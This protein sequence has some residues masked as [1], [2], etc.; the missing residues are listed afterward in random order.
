[1]VSDKLLGLGL[2]LPS[3]SPPVASYI[4][5]KRAGNLVFVSGQLPMHNGT[6]TMTGPMNSSRSIEEAQQ[7][8]E[9]CFLNALA[10]ANLVCELD[11]LS[12]V[13]KLGIFVASDPSFTDQHKVANGASDLAEK[14]FGSDGKHARAAVGVPSLPLGATVEL[15]AV[16]S[17]IS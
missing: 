17:I 13:V 12:G 11:A 5:A 7:A 1:M 15:E 6:L 16:F 10:A 14:I 4:P 3:L 8:M 2:A 9:Q